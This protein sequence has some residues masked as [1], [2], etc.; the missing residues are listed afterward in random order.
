MK[1]PRLK[2]TANKTQLP[3]DKQ[4]YKNNKV[5]LLKRKSQIDFAYTMRHNDANKITWPM[6]YAS[7]PDF[8]QH[9]YFSNTFFK[10]LYSS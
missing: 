10:Y 5:Y 8:K 3:G 1:R 9:R 6:P 2:N 4:N 7:F